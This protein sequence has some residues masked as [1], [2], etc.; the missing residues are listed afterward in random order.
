MSE[1]TITMRIDDKLHTEIKVKATQK[2]MSIKNYI[3]ELVR[4]DL[5]SDEKK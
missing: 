1:K 5:Q 3:L 2:G 4:K